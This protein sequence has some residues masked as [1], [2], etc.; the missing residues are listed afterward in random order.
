MEGMR[1]SVLVVPAI[2]LI[3][4]AVYFFAGAK[5]SSE[6]LEVRARPEPP[7]AVAPQDVL[8][9]ESDR[10][11]ISTFLGA[12]VLSDKQNFALVRAAGRRYI[13]RKIS[14]EAAEKM[15]AAGK[16]GAA[17]IDDLRQPMGAARKGWGVAGGMG[18]VAGKGAAGP[19]AGGNGLRPGH[20]AWN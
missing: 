5:A 16:L 13:R 8:A 20:N 15:V 9:D 19:T 17:S 2:A 18:G 4:G 14:Y 3:G 10:I 11:L 6:R 12:P 7:P 1:F